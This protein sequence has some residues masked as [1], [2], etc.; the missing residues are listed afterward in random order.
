MGGIATGEDAL[1][2]IMAGA[3]AVSVGAMNFVNPYATLAVIDGIEGYMKKHRIEDIH[4]LIG[5]VK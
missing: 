3:T 4:E 1:E 5:C 2:F